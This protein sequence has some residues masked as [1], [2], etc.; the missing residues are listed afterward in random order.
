[1]LGKPNRKIEIEDKDLTYLLD[2]VD[3]FMKKQWIPIPENPAVT[4]ITET[5]ARLR[6][7]V[8]VPQ[9]QSNGYYFYVDDA[10][11]DGYLPFFIVSKEYWNRERCIEDRHITKDIKDFLP[12]GFCE[13]GESTFEYGTWETD[14]LF[15]PRFDSAAIEEGK[16]KLIA[17]GFE[18]IQ[19]PF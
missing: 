10:E 11:E 5:S 2:I 13:S 6:K 17:A 15:V 3:Y 8:E 1:M 16:A 9:K 14:S 4:K 7:L 18:M 19:P 12:V